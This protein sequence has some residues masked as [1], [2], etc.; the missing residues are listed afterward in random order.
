MRRFISRRRVWRGPSVGLLFFSASSR[1]E[2][3]CW[4]M[5]ISMKTSTTCRRVSV[6]WAGQW[7]EF[8]DLIEVGERF[9][10]LDHHLGE[11]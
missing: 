9:V 3:H 6:R 2:V 7:A 8:P 1:N 4:T 11:L 5:F 10:V